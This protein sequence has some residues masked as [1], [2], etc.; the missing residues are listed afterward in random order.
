M[1]DQPGLQPEPYQPKYRYV[2][3]PNGKK[4]RMTE[5]DI[6]LFAGMA[7]DP[8]I[9]GGTVCIGLWYSIQAA[10]ARD[11]ELGIVPIS[12]DWAPL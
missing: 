2:T 3:L 11:K 5:K 8:I 4:Q 7:D 9:R 6:A 1:T 10:Q 12:T